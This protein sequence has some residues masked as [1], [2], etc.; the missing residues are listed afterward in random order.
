MENPL[1]LLPLTDQEAK[2]LND[3]L[4]ALIECVEVA[5]LNNPIS[6]M[7]LKQSAGVLKKVQNKLEGGIND[8]R[9]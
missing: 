2:I 9:N 3:A 6:D 1:F 5:R 7:V 4:I 8:V